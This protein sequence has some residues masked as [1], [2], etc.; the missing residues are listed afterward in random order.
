LSAVAASSSQVN[1]SWTASTDNVAVAGYDVFRSNVQIATTTSTRFSDVGL[2]AGAQYTYA[3]AAFDGAGNVSAQTAPVTVTTPAPDAAPPSTPGNVASSNITA[4][5]VTL[6]WSPS[7]DNVGVAGYR[8]FRNG[9]LVATVSTTSYT[10]SGLAPNTSYSYTV[11]AYDASNNVSVQSQPLII[12]SAA[13]SAVPPSFVQVN[14]NQTSVGSSVSVAL[15]AV[16]SASNTLVAYVIWDNTGSVALT[17]SRGDSFTSVGAAPVWA[18]KFSAQVFYASNI[19]GGMDSVTASF[20]TS[21][22]SFGVMYVLEYAG[23]STVNPVDV[24]VSASG[25]SSTL[26]S[27]SAATTSPNDLIFGAGVSDNVVTAAGSG[28]I[29][30]DMAYGNIVE[31]RIAGAAGSYSAT[32]T[33]SGNMWA[34]QM[35]AFRP[36]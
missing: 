8:V 21:V 20:R 27:G 17:D 10:D 16:T 26:N 32:A 33:Q 13:G 9:S 28:F 25:S 29:G 22:T 14:H 24:S 19:A 7:S 12:T 4:S 1:L 23:I 15:N 34:M 18:G 31:D 30:R 3:I 5:S 11:A 2:S 35:V 6:T 36:K